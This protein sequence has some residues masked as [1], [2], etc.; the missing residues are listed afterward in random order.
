MVRIGL[1]AFRLQIARDSAPPTEIPDE[2][3]YEA[4]TATVVPL[5]DKPDVVPP[6]LQ[7]AALFLYRFAVQPS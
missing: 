2:Y 6:E 4:R 1:P 3:I 5:L 7:E